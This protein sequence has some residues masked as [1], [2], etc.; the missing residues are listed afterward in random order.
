[1]PVCEVCGVRPSA[2]R[3]FWFGR[4]WRICELCYFRRVKAFFRERYQQ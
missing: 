1:M 4:W 2:G 3:H